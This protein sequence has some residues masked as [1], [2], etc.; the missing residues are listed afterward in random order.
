[1]KICA[2]LSRM[3]QIVDQSFSIPLPKVD[4]HGVS[5]REE[6]FRGTEGG[7]LKC[8]T[9]GLAPDEHLLSRGRKQ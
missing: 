9:R 3:Y 2:L 8:S 5:L 7:P 4:V 1:M 6:Q